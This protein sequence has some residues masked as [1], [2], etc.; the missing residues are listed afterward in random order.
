MEDKIKELV[1]DAFEIERDIEYQFKKLYG[2]TFV[3]KN[4][5]T[6]IKKRL[7]SNSLT[8]VGIIYEENNEYYFAPLDRNVSISDVVREYVKYLK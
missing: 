1:Y 2:L 8:P 5:A 3:F 6:I 4:D 7:S